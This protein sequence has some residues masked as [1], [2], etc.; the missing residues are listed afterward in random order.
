MITGAGRLSSAA[1]RSPARDGTAGQE[2]TAA[3]LRRSDLTR[4]PGYQTPMPSKAARMLSR[5]SAVTAPLSD[6]SQ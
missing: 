4:T 2:G 6:S 1:A 5:V 3:W